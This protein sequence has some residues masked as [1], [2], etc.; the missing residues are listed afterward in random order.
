MPQSLEADC[1]A[2]GLFG[3]NAKPG[4][5]ASSR[6]LALRRRTLINGHKIRGNKLPMASAGRFVKN[7]RNVLITAV[8]IVFPLQVRQVT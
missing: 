4:V 3:G 7:D 8:R 6:D 5:A 2:D 1:G